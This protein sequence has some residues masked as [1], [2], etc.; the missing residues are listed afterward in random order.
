MPASPAGPIE[1]DLFVSG[2]FLNP[3]EVASDAQR[4]LLQLAGRA[5]GVRRVLIETRPEYVT[6]Q[7]LAAAR[8]AA[9]S[10]FLEV[11]IGLESANREIREKRI[12]KGFT[13]R[14]FEQ[15]ARTISSAGAGIVV[16]TL[17]KPIDTGEAEAIDDVVDTAHRVF[18]L[19]RDVPSSIRMA[20]QP[21]FVAPRTPLERAFEAGRYRPPWLWSVAEAVQRI[22]T[23]GPL[24]VGLSDEGMGPQ[25]RAHNCGKCD[26]DVIAAL[27]T[28]N[29]TAST[30]ALIH[31]SCSCRDE[32][33]AALA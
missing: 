17:L 16:H 20:L 21:C 27:A 4:R 11:A 29:R 6:E 33:Q 19:A 23:R 30:N 12:R 8:R 22:A 32:W 13:W 5:P 26:D 2:S 3:D 14:H 24:Q 10:A 18:T 7:R 9:G 15:A 31:L 1:L 28:F 25:R